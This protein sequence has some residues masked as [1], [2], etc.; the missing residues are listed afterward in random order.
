MGVF[1]QEKREKLKLQ[2]KRK[3]RQNLFI[4]LFDVSEE[5]EK[6]FESYYAVC[7]AETNIPRACNILY[8]VFEITKSPFKVRP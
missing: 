3:V 4:Y 6:Q 1:F 5:R 7:F 2:W 8:S